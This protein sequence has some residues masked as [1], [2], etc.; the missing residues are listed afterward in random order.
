MLSYAGGWAT[1]II[2]LLLEH[3]NGTIRFHAMQSILSA[4]FVHLVSVVGGFILSITVLSRDAAVTFSWVVFGVGVVLWLV[5]M[6]LAYR[7][8]RYRLPVFGRIAGRLA[9]RIPAR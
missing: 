1:G 7:G 2:F 8:I 6:L 9:E 3:D 5:L 4:G